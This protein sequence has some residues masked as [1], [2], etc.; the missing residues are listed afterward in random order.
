M[1]TL[2]CKKITL[3]MAGV[4]IHVPFCRSKCA[5]CDFYSGP[6]KGLA[7]PYATAVAREWQ[8]RRAE[9][10]EPVKTIYLGGGTPSLL[11]PAL[12]SDIISP[13]AKAQPVEELTIEA[14]PEDVTP[15][16]LDLI[17]SLGVN[18]V[19][20]GIQSFDARLLRAIGRRHDPALAMAALDA[21]ASDGINFSADLMWG[22]PG[23]S[24]Q[25]WLRDIDSLLSFR[26][27]HISAYLLSFERGT[28]LW[29][30]LQKGTLKEPDELSV[31]RMYAL[32]CTT[33]A[34]HSYN[35]Y[36]ISNF[37][38]PG[39]HSRHNS[40]YWNLTPYLGL[41]PAA[42]SFTQNLRRFN[43]SNLPL[44]IKTLTEGKTAYVIDEETPDNAFNDYLM[45]RL[46]TRQGL[47]LRQVEARWGVLRRRW[48]EK[49]IPSEVDRLGEVISI[50]EQNW[51]TSDAIIRQM[52]YV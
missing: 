14:N 28:R 21:L 39:F 27:P 7:Q 31:T 42:H 9:L 5:Y 11:P 37:A 13:I 19:S 49:H 12:L 33:L 47:D 24:P 51:L 45:I 29:A 18:R 52:I 30:Q 43:P 40:S 36:E 48:L 1:P 8:L 20:I 3:F 22:L 10:Q 26:P 34:S 46:R 15:Q 25:M 2:T 32:L 50:P 41:G 6:L 35:H 4:Y 16:W 17:R 38:L 23:Q 44:Y